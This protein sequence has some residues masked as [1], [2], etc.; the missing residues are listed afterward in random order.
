MGQL[1]AV[2]RSPQPHLGQVTPQT[3]E[4]GVWVGAV[5]ES[6]S[7]PLLLFYKYI[8]FNQN[9]AIDIKTNILIATC[10]LLHVL[11]K[12]W[13]KTP[14]DGDNAETHRSQL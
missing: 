8:N 10:V 5:T 13:C 7:L 6:T 3:G 2:T 11:M 12:S 14:E 9:C 4:D 1:H